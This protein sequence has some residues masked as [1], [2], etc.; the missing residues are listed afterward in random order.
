[1]KTIAITIDEDMVARVDRL[2][3]GNRS[4]VIREAVQEYV[5]RLERLQAEQ[6]EAAIIRRHKSRLARQAAALVRA[7]A[8]P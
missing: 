1:M 7:Q 6:Q 4:R 8:K 2:A 3:K 5:A